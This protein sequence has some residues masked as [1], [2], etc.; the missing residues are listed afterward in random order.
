MCDR[1]QRS[2]LAESTRRQTKRRHRDRFSLRHRISRRALGLVRFY[3]KDGKSMILFNW[4]ES[5]KYRC[6]R[7]RSAARNSRL[8]QSL[9][10]RSSTARHRF[11]TGRRLRSPGT[12]LVWTT[13]PIWRSWM[14]RFSPA[15]ASCRQIR[16]SPFSTRLLAS[17]SM[18]HLTP[19]RSAIQC[20]LLGTWE[21]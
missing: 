7:R 1:C 17:L 21:I 20:R 10:L 15:S 12:S 18:V 3:F 14:R 5:L 9:L 13:T 11:W 19:R 16:R 4:L 2:S 8:P 6:R